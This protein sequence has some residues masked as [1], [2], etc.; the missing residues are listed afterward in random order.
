MGMSALIE[1]NSGAKWERERERESARERLSELCKS[2]LRLRSF[3]SK[4]VFFSC[5]LQTAACVWYSVIDA[6]FRYF[7]LIFSLVF[8]YII[9]RF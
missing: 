3:F 7:P 4:E 5:C 6:E 2:D 9:F 8:I 1:M